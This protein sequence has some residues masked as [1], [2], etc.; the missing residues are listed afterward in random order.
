MSALPVD[1]QID[2]Q[3]ASQVDSMRRDR[4]RAMQVSLTVGFV[5]LIVKFLAYR[6]SNSAALQA[7]AYESIVNVLAAG[8]G[9]Y[10]VK[11]ANEPADA[12]HPYGHGKF[13]DL[14]GAVEGGSLAIA[15]LMIFYESF[16]KM[17]MGPDFDDLS[18]G[19]IMNGLA[20]GA[21]GLL[22]LYLVK[23]G[24]TLHSQ[25]IVGDGQHVLSDFYSS[26]GV[27][28]GLVIVYLTGWGW[29]DGL[30]GFAVGMIVMW[31]A[32]SL[33]RTAISAL[34]DKADPDL[35]QKIVKSINNQRGLDIITVHGVRVFRA[36]RTSHLDLHVVVPE[37]FD[38]R[39]AH[40]LVEAFGTR[41]IDDAGLH[42]ECHSH[43]DPC[44][45]KLCK[46]CLVTGCPIRI[47]A[48]EA[49]SMLTIDEASRLLA[50]Y[51]D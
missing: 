18:L 2:I 5:I 27:V 32:L 17:W 8:F 36:G 40:N 39:K 19:L 35:L 20:G 41:L 37:F 6:V 4:T 45:R 13:E 29:V 48:F 7:D 23:R 10:A 14:S 31:Q 9:L 28:G 11:A 25:A 30:L 16:K 43:I 34:T 3:K 47:Q 33:L 1:S 42:G 15:S 46:Q 38:V 24:R 49:Q 26:I 44:F 50:D 22:G 51:E 21:N 12:D